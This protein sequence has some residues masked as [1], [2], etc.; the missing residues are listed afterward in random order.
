MR[1][2]DF[3]LRPDELQPKRGAMQKKRDGAQRATPSRQ[4]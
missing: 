3:E 2:Q 4:W 1:S